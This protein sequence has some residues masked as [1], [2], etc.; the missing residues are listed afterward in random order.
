MYSWR[1]GLLVCVVVFGCLVDVLVVT[2][3]LSSCSEVFLGKIVAS[4]EKM[5]PS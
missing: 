3:S 4:V 1:A 2:L 5:L